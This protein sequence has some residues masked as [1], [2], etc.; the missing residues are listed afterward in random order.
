MVAQVSYRHNI[1]IYYA[2]GDLKATFTRVRLTLIYVCRYA[3][4][5]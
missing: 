1:I 3:C 4:M 5:Y 2:C